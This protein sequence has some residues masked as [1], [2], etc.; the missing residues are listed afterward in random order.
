MSYTLN[1]HTIAV[2]VSPS[3]YIII[4]CDNELIK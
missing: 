3:N 1:G 4:K 2:T